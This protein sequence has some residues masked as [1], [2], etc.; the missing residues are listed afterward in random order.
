[1]LNPKKAS[2]L[3]KMPLIA[4]KETAS[5]ISP[6]LQSLF[7]QSLDTHNLPND[8]KQANIIPIF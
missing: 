4:L 5:E 6:I 3:D 2:G 1:M 7:Q 8:W